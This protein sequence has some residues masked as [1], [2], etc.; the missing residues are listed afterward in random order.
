MASYTPIR[1]TRSLLAASDLS[2]KQFYYVGDN[3][4]GAC[5]IVGSATGA[6]GF[7]FLQNNPEAGEA[8]VIGSIGGGSKAIAGA[9]ISAAQLDLKANALGE[10][11]PALPGDI[12][13][14]KSMESAADGDYFEVEPVYTVGKT[15]LLTMLAAADLSTKQYFYVGENGSGAYNV[16]GGTTGAIGTGFLQNAPAA[17]GDGCIINGV[18]YPFSKAISGAAI[19][20]ANV[21]LMS[22]ALGKLIPTTAAGDIVVAISTASAAAADETITVI[23]VLYR[24]HA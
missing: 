3:G 2:A 24:K 16:I 15:T 8:C 11:I 22:N 18:G 19:S 1:S 5:A 4:S 13:V 10:M 6:L 7:G 20:A 14:A 17:V 21:E 12:V 23:P 9:V